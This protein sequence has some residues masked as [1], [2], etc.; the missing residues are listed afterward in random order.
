[1]KTL[2]FDTETTGLVDS[3][4]LPSHPS[5]P[6]LV[7]LCC[8]LYDEY[9]ELRSQC[10]LIVKPPEGVLIPKEATD[11]HG[12]TTEMA[13]DLGVPLS[14]AVAVYTNMRAQVDIQV[15]HNIE[16]DVIVMNAALHRLQAKPRHPGPAKR[17]CTM[18]ELA[19]TV[20]LPPTPKMVAAGFKKNKPPNLSEAIMHCFGETLEGA[21]DALID[22][23]GAARLYFWCKAHLADFPA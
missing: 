6:H 9:D 20:N 3:K 16:F 14:V 15:A 21:H 23:A 1:M 10:A 2:V 19:T 13:N 8:L 18:R 7:Q 12:I 5:Q 17:F 4:K 11:V 22:A